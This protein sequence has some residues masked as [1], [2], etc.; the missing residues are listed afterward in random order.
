MSIFNNPKNKRS[1]SLKNMLQSLRI[2]FKNKFYK[3]CKIQSN[4]LQKRCIP[5]LMT[6]KMTSKK[7]WKVLFSNKYNLVYKNILRY[8]IIK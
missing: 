3:I 4:K 7:K 6:H 1:K 5:P 2:L 8:K